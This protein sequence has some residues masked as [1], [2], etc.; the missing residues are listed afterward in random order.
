MTARVDHRFD[1][2]TLRRPSVAARSAA[3]EADGLAKHYG[4]IVAVADLSLAAEPGEILGVLGPNGAGKTTAIRVLTTILAPTRGAFEVA[5]LPH[6]RPD[7]I[8]RRIGVLPESAG[9]PEQQTGEEYV[10]YHARLYGHGR[11]SARR[12]AE[13]LLADVGLADR[14]RSL[15][16]SYSR[17]MRQRLGLARALVNE[18]Q[19]VFLDEPTLGLDPAGQRH[20]LALVRRIAR[21]RGATVLLSS[22]LLAEVEEICSRVL[23]LNRGRVVASGTVSEVARRAAA[24]RT[25]TL[26]V[27]ADYV[28]RVLETL[29][30][31][32]SID[33]VE[34]V[35]EHLGSVI[36]TLSRDGGADTMNRG[37]R[38]LADAGV[39]I[40]AFELERARLS[41][42][43]LAMTETTR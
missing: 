31:M 20:V 14:R 39:P 17:G 12:V 35:D 41:D 32:K 23:I 30:D 22:H 38:A 5:G 6:T 25:A 33:S 2:P 28:A 29:A 11:A 7:E 34:A 1:Q 10:R 37:I 4:R 16:A 24:P 15:I 8:R 19:V 42:A 43:F 21:E 26:R 3:I 18:P 9:Y 40:L 36:V 13:T 27:P